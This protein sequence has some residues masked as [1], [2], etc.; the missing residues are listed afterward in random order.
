MRLASLPWGLQ[1]GVP[2]QRFRDSAPELQVCRIKKG[3]V[4]WTTSIHQGKAQRSARTLTVSPTKFV[5]CPA[6]RT[7][8]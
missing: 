5:P 2:S 4:C 7:P 3:I 8:F 1:D 6:V